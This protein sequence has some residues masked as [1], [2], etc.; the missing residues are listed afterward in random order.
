MPRKLRASK[1]R[2]RPIDVCPALFAYLTWRDFGAATDLLRP[3][4][5][6]WVLFPMGPA[7]HEHAW[8]A[9]EHDA[10]DAWIERY[11]GSRPASWW[12]WSAPELRRVVGAFTVLENP[13]ERCQSSGV[14]FLRPDNWSDP[15]EVE[16]QAAYLSR[17]ALWRDGERERV[18]DDAFE[19]VTWS[20]SGAA[21]GRI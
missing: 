12:Y 4:D 8:R 1:K 20:L 9:I 13:R 3:Q 15:P 2:T 6:K 5:S 17:L 10:V 11:P 18:S 7:S 19:P 21:N 16:T 14:P